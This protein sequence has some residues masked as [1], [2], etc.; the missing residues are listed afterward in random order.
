MT[1]IEWVKPE[2]ETLSVE[3]TLTG[4]NNTPVETEVSQTGE[5]F[6]GPNS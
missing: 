6:G 4:P 1:K 2:L 3:E 5:P